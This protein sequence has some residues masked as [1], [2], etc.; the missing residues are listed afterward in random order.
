MTSNSKE[1]V[2]RE[3]K[4]ALDGL[5]SMRERLIEL[6]AERLS[7]PALED[8]WVLDRDGELEADGRLL[9]L[10][11][12]GKGAS[13]AF[14]GP[15]SWDGGMKIRVENETRIDDVEETRRLFENLGFHAVRRYQKVREEWQLGAVT[16]ALDHTSIG[17]FV[18]LEG[19]GAETVA[20]RCGF[21]PKDGERLSYLGIYDE[22]RKKNPDLPRDM[23]LP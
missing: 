3:F 7:A 18:E 21:S 12:D 20:K 1:S 10:R 5:E 6:E 17:D 14:K 13:M 19:T 16:I 15:A 8:N 2:E 9:R 11:K 23:L 4:F 22:H